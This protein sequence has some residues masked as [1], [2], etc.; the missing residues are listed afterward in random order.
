MSLVDTRCKGAEL[1]IATKKH[2]IV[3]RVKLPWDRRMDGQRSDRSIG[4]AG[5][6]APRSDFFAP[7]FLCCSMVTSILL[8]DDFVRNQYN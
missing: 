3:T 4:R 6:L 7:F 1:S 2:E 5:N 8:I